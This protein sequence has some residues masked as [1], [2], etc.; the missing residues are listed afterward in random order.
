M[1]FAQ[2]LDLY[3]DDYFDR[4]LSHAAIFMREPFGLSNLAFNPD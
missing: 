2:S 1:K 3:H 4:E